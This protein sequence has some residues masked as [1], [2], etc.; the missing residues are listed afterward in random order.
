MAARA[1]RK[2]QQKE[3]LLLD[4][5][6]LSHE[7]RGIA[8][9][10]GKVVFVVGAL[11]GEQVLARF[12]SQR[13]SYAEATALEVIRSSPERVTPH[14]RYFGVCGGCSLQHL[15]SAAQLAFK[16][17][18][19]HERLAHVVTAGSYQQL[20]VISGEVFGYRRKA[21]LAVRWVGKKGKALVGFKE[22]QSGF[23]TDMDE[24][25]VLSP[26]I[27][28]LIATLSEL[29]SQLA[30]KDQLPQ[31]EV[32]VG[33]ASADATGGDCALVFR[34]L[35]K[36][37]EADHALLLQFG[38]THH[39]DIYLQPHG[40]DSVHKLYPATGPERLYY[41]L[42]DYRLRMAFHPQ[43]FTQVNAGINQQMLQRALQ[44][45]DLQTTDR[46]LDL[47]CGLGN[48]T[49]P[50]ARTA[51]AVV[52]VEGSEQ[53]VKRGREN[54]LAN[55]L[56]NVEFHAADLTKPAE[57]HAF[58]REKFDKI[59]LDPPRSGAQEV[60]AALAALKPSRIVYVSCNPATLARDA[61]LLAELGYALEAAGAMD[62]FP[63]TS[64]VEAIALFTPRRS[65]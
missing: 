5:S 57:G 4:I 37:S 23:I 47:F 36:L 27:G 3:P 26:R 64:H 1:R 53:M 49:L 28:T 61:G 34:H 48:F 31:I 11:T 51:Q 40:P 16:S 44:L 21:R 12:T 39:I 24:C 30:C 7:G 18:V 17:A 62:M 29:V 8:H 33:D 55:Q 20:P 32:A 46:V 14:C 41:D 19:L 25:P 45:L 22:Q 6:K 13:G 50:M 38:A 42:P 52:G 58:L 9:H 10:E 56:A 35:Q 43:D 2:L 63:H 60:L 59:L 54:A 15:D 65:R